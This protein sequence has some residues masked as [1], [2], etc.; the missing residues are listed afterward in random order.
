MKPFSGVGITAVALTGILCLQPAHADFFS[1]LKKKAESAVRDLAPNKAKEAMG[2]DT[3]KPKAKPAEQSSSSKK[4]GGTSAHG[5]SSASN[6]ASGVYVDMDDLSTDRMPL[7]A[8]ALNMLRFKFEPNYD[9]DKRA[10]I[11]VTKQHIICHRVT[12]GNLVVDTRVFTQRAF[13]GTGCIGQ[14]IEVENPSEFADR[15]G[16]RYVRIFDTAVVKDRNPDFA[17]R[18]LKDKML[19]ALKKAGQHMSAQFAETGGW[20]GKYDFDTGEL[21][22]NARPFDPLSPSLKGR[23]LPAN[24]QSRDA[25]KVRQG[26]FGTQFNRLKVL[27]PLVDTGVETVA[28]DRLLGEGHFKMSTRDAE[29]L[30]SNK[31]VI[32]GG[33]GMAV[34]EFTVEKTEKGAALARL[35]KVVLLAKKGDKWTSLEPYMTIPASAFPKAVTVAVIPKNG[36]HEAWGVLGNQEPAAEYADASPEHHFSPGVGE[37]ADQ[38]E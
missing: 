21:V 19:A 7:L 6:I 20:R 36:A 23:L 1:K 31:H 15:Y 30:L 22:I 32:E 2:I 18:E 28:F 37:L 27:W 38:T 8:G 35:D 25:Y 34:V 24:E 13:D 10:L 17:A 14:R 4:G 11:D 16:W 5:F 12:D 29:K 26:R 9:I 33:G 3:D